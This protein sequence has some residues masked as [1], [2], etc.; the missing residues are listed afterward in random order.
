MVKKAL[1]E[2][3]PAQEAFLNEVVRKHL[4]D[5]CQY[6]LAHGT[7]PKYAL[8]LM[9]AESPLPGWTSIYVDYARKKGWVASDSSRVLADGWKVAAAFLKR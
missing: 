1:T 7:L 3:P 2:L 4:V 8:N 6:E 5:W 9:S